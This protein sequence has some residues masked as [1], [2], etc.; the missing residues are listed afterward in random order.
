MSVVGVVGLNACVISNGLMSWCARLER[1]HSIEGS[2]K[3]QCHGLCERQRSTD[4][5]RS[6]YDV[7]S[8]CIGKGFRAFLMIV[9]TPLLWTLLIIEML[10]GVLGATLTALF[11]A[12]WQSC[13]MLVVH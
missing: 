6:C 7:L 11:Y 8:C 2:G 4:N 13:V 3:R 12:S 10:A 1:K 5:D 9:V